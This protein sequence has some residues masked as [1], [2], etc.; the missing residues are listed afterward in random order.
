MSVPGATGSLL[1]PCQEQLGACHE[2]GIG[3]CWERVRSVPGAC[4][5]RARSV[6]GTCQVRAKNVPRTSHERVPGAC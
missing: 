5:E 1:R 4:E 2:R 6:P 3:A